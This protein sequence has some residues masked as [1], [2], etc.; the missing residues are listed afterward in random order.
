M[1]GGISCTPGNQLTTRADDHD[2]NRQKPTEAVNNRSVVTGYNYDAANR[3]S[4]QTF[5]R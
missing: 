3:L 4:S 5:N 2:G 1:P